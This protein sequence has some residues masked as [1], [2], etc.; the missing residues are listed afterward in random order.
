[1]RELR[2]RCG[3]IVFT[4]N[5]HCGVCGRTLGFDPFTN[6][7]LSLDEGADGVL[8]AADGQRY[9]LCANR[10]QHEI[11]NGVFPIGGGDR[12]RSCAL[13]R[14]IPV[15]RRKKNLARWHR[16]ERAKRRMISGLSE[17][18]LQADIT[19]GDTAEMRFDFLEDQRSHP[20]VLES[21]VSTGYK[22]GVITINVME[23][24]DVQ[25][26][27]QRE[28][29]GER[30]RTLL[31]H[32]RHEAGHFFYPLLV[33]NSG[34]FRQIFGDPAADYDAALNLYYQ[35]G[36]ADEW[37]KNYISEYACSHALEDWAECFAHYLHMQDALET[38]AARGISPAVKNLPMETQLMLWT[39]L[40]VS[41]NELSRSLGLRDAYPF[42]LTP[43]VATKL[44]YVHTCIT[45]FS[46][47]L[48]RGA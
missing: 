6:S 40:S 48:S 38:A 24:D 7:M 45:Q 32:F 3:Q 37:G 26:V 18:G 29:M 43:G 10:A 22:N 2:C 31:G 12:C 47:T 34:S 27:K 28:L 39:D 36:P 35:N 5:T 16:L 25:R 19:A 41:V 44:T 42:S 9:T 20:D 33:T 46:S 11:C 23:A 13:N 17:L 4:D 14:T 15:L 1:V 8:V 21:F 30:Y